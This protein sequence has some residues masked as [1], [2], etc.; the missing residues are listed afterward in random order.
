MRSYRI[1]LYAP[2]GSRHGSGRRS[3][4]R[5]RA[6]KRWGIAVVVDPACTARYQRF[7]GTDD[8]RRAAVLRMAAAPDVDLAMA[9]RGGYGWSRLLDAPRL[10]RARRVGQALDRAQRFHGVPAGRARARRDEDV[11]RTDG[12]LRF[13]RRR[14]SRAFTVEH[15]FALLDADRARRVLRARRA[16]LRR[17]R[18]AVGRQSRAGRA[19][20]G[21][22]AS[23]ADRRRHPV[24]RG[25]QRASVPDRADALPA[26]LRRRA[27]AAEG[28]AARHV[29]RLR[30]RGATTTATTRRRWSRRRARGSACR[31]S[32]G[33]RSGIAATS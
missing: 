18:H 15:C 9:V 27:G 30:A 12:R 8:E 26:A 16:R 2:A 5:W 22:A 10:S 31:S 24:S 28:G 19:S 13:R 33:C 6:S 32:P 23:A 11:R 1:G 7:A 21:H 14:R 17:R 29:Q 3:I 25:D 4:A 20:R